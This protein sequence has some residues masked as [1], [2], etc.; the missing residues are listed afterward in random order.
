MAE[1]DQLKVQF[2]TSVKRSGNPRERR[3]GE[4]EHAGDTADALGKTAGLLTLSGF[5]QAVVRLCEPLSI[6]ASMQSR[7][8]G[9]FSLSMFPEG[10]SEDA[11]EAK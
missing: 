7:A 2:R 11:I 5:E 10:F 3:R 4:C 9:S 1:H 8:L 6:Q